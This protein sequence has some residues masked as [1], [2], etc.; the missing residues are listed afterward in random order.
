MHITKIN[1][2]P[3]NLLTLNMPD[4]ILITN[5]LSDIMNQMSMYLRRFGLL[6]IGNIPRG[7]LCEQSS[8]KTR[9]LRREI[10]QSMISV[11]RE[12]CYWAGPEQ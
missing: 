1:L 12:A 9:D 2:N 6:F 3:V 4:D 7:V 5:Q 10:M 11:H 8:Q